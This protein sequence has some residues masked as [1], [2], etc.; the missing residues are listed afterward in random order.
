MN[1]KRDSRIVRW[2]YLT[3]D[4]SPPRLTSLC[5]LFWRCVLWTPVRLTIA[6]TVVGG[7]VGGILL[8]AWKIWPVTVALAVIGLSVWALIRFDL[9]D[10]RTDA[11]DRRLDAATARVSRSVIW[12]GAKAVKSRVCPLV[13]IGETHVDGIS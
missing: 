8:V 6:L 13:T 11:L 4:C 7:L 1:L 9:D 12:Q 5:A 2:A 10:V 3:D